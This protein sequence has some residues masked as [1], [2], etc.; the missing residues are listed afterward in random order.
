MTTT[1]ADRAARRDTRRSDLEEELHTLEDDV[2]ILVED[3]FDSDKPR[4]IKAHVGE[5]IKD[6]LS[7]VTVRGFVDP[8]SLTGSILAL[9][10]GSNTDN[11]KQQVSPSG[12]PQG[13]DDET[14]QWLQQLATFFG[15]SIHDAV[16]NF[17]TWVRA[18]EGEDDDEIGR[19]L[20]V[21]MRGFK[22]QLKAND[23][24]GHL[25][26]ETKLAEK[27]TELGKVEKERDGAQ[28]EVTRL[29]ANPGGATPAL[30]KAQQDLAHVTRE[31][32]GLQSDNDDLH[33]ENQALQARIASGINKPLQD[34]VDDIVKNSL[35]SRWSS[36]IEIQTKKV[37]DETLAVLKR[38]RKGE[39]TS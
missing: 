38:D 10:A 18:M 39:K 4:P 25:E 30:Q 6:L 13:L 12:N 26:L 17:R 15:V 7:G 21:A 1:S 23:R 28:A 37:K 36:N 31:R 9:P 16:G 22:G 19:R 3:F 29:R 32:D 27:T 2:V 35:K 8:S 34:A 5:Q 14:M 33:R 11:G 24:R 20:A